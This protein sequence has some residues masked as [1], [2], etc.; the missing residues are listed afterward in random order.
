[1]AGDDAD[2]DDLERLRSLLLAQEQARLARLEAE[3]RAQHEAQRDLPKR[4]PELIGDA[5]GEAVQRRRQSIVDALFP[6]IMPAIR[7]SI[8]EYLRTLGADL[9]RLVE[10]KFTLRGLRWSLEARRRGLSYA[11][12][13]LQHA[14][15]YRVEHLFLIQRGSGLLLQRRSVAGEAALDG[16]ATSGMLSAISDFVRDTMAS[17]DRSTLSSAAVGEHLLWVCDGPRA[18]LAAFIRGA[19]PAS[20]RTRLQEM[21]EAAHREFESLLVG[22]PEAAVSD[23]GLHALLDLEALAPALPTPAPKRSLRVVLVAFAALLLLALALGWQQQRRITSLVAAVD[24]I[25]GVEVLAV[26][27]SWFGFGR[28]TIDALVDPEVGDPLSALAPALR[29]G[30]DLAPR[31]RSFVSLDH[32]VVRARARRLLA[33]APT[34]GVEL[35]DGELRIAG[36]A[37]AEAKARIAAQ[38]GWLPGVRRVDLSALEVSAPPPDPLHVLHEQH[39]PALSALPVLFAPGDAQAPDP[40]SLQALIERLRLLARDAAAA[41]V[42]V[43]LFVSGGAD[44][45]GDAAG[46]QRLRRARAEWLLAQLQHEPDLAQVPLRFQLSA[47]IESDNIDAR[48]AEVRFDR[49]HD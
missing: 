40:G 9:N 33:L 11:E 2:D 8:A 31:W 19:P 17:E 45:S 44:G 1:M 24:A 39:A 27:A 32:D 16:D 25:A 49:R 41:G 14:L 20:L 47:T 26:D 15:G 43:D 22:A 18:I 36:V 23:A 35:V 6:V 38:A 5:L 30:L 46:N 4:L 37:S 34:L 48:A 21:L 3:Q 10:S 28:V 29:D 42:H 7:R 13:A 12:V